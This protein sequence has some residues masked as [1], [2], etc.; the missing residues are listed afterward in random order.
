MS[1]NVDGPT[2]QGRPKLRWKDL[3][4]ADLRQKHLNISLVSDRSTWR[5][6]IRPV[7]ADS[8][9]THYEWNKEMKRQ[10]SE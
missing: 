2:Y 10:F 6:A 4:N 3:V 8:T 5:N 1:F 7:T 9:P